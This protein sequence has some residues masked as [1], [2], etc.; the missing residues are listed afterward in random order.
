MNEYPKML[1]SRTHH[2]EEGISASVYE[3]RHDAVWAFVWSEDEEKKL[4]SSW[5]ESLSDLPP[6]GSLPLYAAPKA[7]IEP[8]HEAE[9][10]GD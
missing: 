7:A 9:K 5:I 10:V 8:I 3:P 2:T 6:R 1:Y 4:G